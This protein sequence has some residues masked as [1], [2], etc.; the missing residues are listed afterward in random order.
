MRFQLPIFK[1]IAPPTFHLYILWCL[2]LP[3][4]YIYHIFHSYSCNLTTIFGHSNISLS[5]QGTFSLFCGEMTIIF[6][7]NNSRKHFLS[8]LRLNFC[9][10]CEESYNYNNHRPHKKGTSMP[11][12]SSFHMSFFWAASSSPSIIISVFLT[13]CPPQMRETASL[14]ECTEL[15]TS[16]FNN[17][18]NPNSVQLK[19]WVLSLGRTASWHW[20]ESGRKQSQSQFWLWRVL[21]RF[22]SGGSNLESSKYSPP[23]RMIMSVRMK[24]IIL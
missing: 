9:A 13:D 11:R 12:N 1:T 17:L 18:F 10:Y 23:L 5:H 3:H 7:K 22:Q 14:T 16:F 21:I 6:W 24:V 19:W 4:W 15:I 8:T 20:E 2:L